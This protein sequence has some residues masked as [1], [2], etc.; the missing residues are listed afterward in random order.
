ME[1]G[2]ESLFDENKLKVLKVLVNSE[3]DLY[4][5]E[6]ARQ[7]KLAPSTCFRVLNQLVSLGLVKRKEVKTLITYSFIK[8]ERTNLI[9]QW[10]KEKKNP[11]DLFLEKIREIPE[12]IELIVDSVEE[13]KAKVIL[14]LK[15]ETCKTKELADQIKKDFGFEI[16][17]LELTEG[18]F[19]QML[20]LGLIKKKSLWK[21]E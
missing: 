4:L 15:K 2:I 21:R 10:L 6:I 8:N 7:A 9:S 3:E 1:R 16:N 11:F 18:Q 5:R 17:S 14:V 20:D 19:Q 12:A 13:K